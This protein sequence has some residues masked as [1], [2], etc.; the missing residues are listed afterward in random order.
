MWSFT[1]STLAQQIWAGA[2][3]CLAYVCVFVITFTQKQ[4]FYYHLEAATM[5]KLIANIFE[6]I[7]YKIYCIE[8]FAVVVT[9]SNQVHEIAIDMKRSSCH[10][11]TGI[12]VCLKWPKV[13]NERCLRKLSKIVF[14]NLEV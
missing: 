1:A 10:E 4:G 14:E 7:Q 6:N 3:C 13:V 2:V 9:V 11:K 5:C 12:V 8:L